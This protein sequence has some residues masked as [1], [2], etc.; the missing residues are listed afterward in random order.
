MLQV[1][2]G[3][4]KDT[5]EAERMFLKAAEGGDADAQ[6]AV[7]LLRLI[8]YSSG[9]SGDPNEPLDWFKRA[10]TQGE[11]LA[12]IYLGA[13]YTRGGDGRLDLVGAAD[14]FRLCGE[15]TLNGQ[16]LYAY[17]TA[18]EFG[19]G[20]ARDRVKTYVMYGV[21]IGRGHLEKAEI[22]REMTLQAL[23]SEE[24]KQAYAIAVQMVRNSNVGMAEMGVGTT[25]SR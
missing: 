15:A 25:G 9:S 1:G 19:I 5:A 12:M 7:G 22:K 6:T 10:A 8:A 16:C 2:R 21:A 3:T 13:L 11:P 18:L 4:A 24:V 23:S 20:T 14:R 17:A